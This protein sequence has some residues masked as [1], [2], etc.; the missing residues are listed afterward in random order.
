VK[1]NPAAIE[2]AVIDSW[3]HMKRDDPIWDFNLTAKRFP[4]AID[5]HRRLVIAMLE[6]G[7]DPLRAIEKASE[8]KLSYADMFESGQKWNKGLAVYLK[9]WAGKHGLT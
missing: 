6:T 8:G 4:E 2:A 1:L 5:A 7:C 9:Q 3:R